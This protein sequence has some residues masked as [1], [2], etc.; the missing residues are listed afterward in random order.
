MIPK[1]M[2]YGTKEQRAKVIEQFYGQVRK[3]IKHRIAAPVLAMAYIDYATSEQRCVA[4][5]SEKRQK[6][7]GGGG[8]V[9]V[10]FAASDSCISRTIP[11][12]PILLFSFHIPADLP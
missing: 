1:L 10:W 7:W 6:K 5:A 3:L 2:T 12:L 8:N 11:H 9:S 4:L